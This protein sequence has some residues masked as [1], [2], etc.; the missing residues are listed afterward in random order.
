VERQARILAGTELGQIQSDQQ[1][2]REHVVAQAQEKTADA[3]RGMS[4]ASRV[5]GMTAEKR[6]ENKAENAAN[7]WTPPAPTPTPGQVITREDRYKQEEYAWL[8]R[9]RDGEKTDE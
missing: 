9:M 4:N 5:D 8:R 2:F 7:A 3:S 6:A 1:T